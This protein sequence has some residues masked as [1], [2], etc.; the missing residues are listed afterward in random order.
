MKGNI[1]KRKNAIIKRFDEAIKLLCEMYGCSYVFSL[2]R[3][4]IK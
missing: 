1:S 2:A 3:Y 4:F